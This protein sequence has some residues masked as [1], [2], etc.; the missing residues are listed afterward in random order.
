M[1]GVKAKAGAGATLAALGGLA[2]YAV[3]SG[4]EPSST[5]A[6]KTQPVEVRT[7][8]IRRTVHV[9]KHE[10]PR[11]RRTKAPHGPARAAAPAASAAPAPAPAAVTS[12]APARPAPARVV[13]APA[14]AHHLTTRTSGGSG[15][16]GEDEHE[17][18]HESEHEHEGGDD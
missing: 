17:R 12:A 8:T 14:P 7:E 5:Q 16:G 13:S 4:D 10:K 2:A 6:A 9:V 1:N 15:R 3:A 18:E 11:H